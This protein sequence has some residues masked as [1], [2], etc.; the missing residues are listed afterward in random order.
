MK[1]KTYFA[2]E[3]EF[4]AIMSSKDILDDSLTAPEVGETEGPDHPG[5]I[6]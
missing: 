3:S 2:P 5:F 6:D 1:K 4:L